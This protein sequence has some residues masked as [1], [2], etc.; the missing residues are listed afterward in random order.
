MK[1][2]VWRFKELYYKRNQ[3][4]R[5]LKE[6]PK[7]RSLVKT[8]PSETAK[9]PYTVLE[10]SFYPVEY[11]LYDWLRTFASGRSPSAISCCACWHRTFTG[12]GLSTMALCTTKKKQ[13][14][15]P[16]LELGTKLYREPTRSSNWIQSFIK[17]RSLKYFKM[18]EEASSVNLEVI[19]EELDTLKAKLDQYELRDIY[20]CDEMGV[21]TKW[22]TNWTLDVIKTS[23]VKP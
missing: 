23:G 6:E 22:M 15:D 16:A 8:M 19:K 7:L 9:T 10:R 4:S 12:R 2:S 5:L 13:G 14:T 17:S 20:N 11:L 18:T 1:P 21:Y 3:V